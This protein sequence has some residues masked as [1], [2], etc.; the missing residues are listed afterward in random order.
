MPYGACFLAEND[1]VWLIF[2][3]F[4]SDVTAVMRQRN[5]TIVL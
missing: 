3:H 4:A 1:N 5:A 2:R